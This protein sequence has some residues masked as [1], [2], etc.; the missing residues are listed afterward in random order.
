MRGFAGSILCMAAA[1][2]MVGCGGDGGE[3]PSAAEAPKRRAAPARPATV[4]TA[5]KPPAPPAALDLRLQPGQQFPL[6]KVVEQTLTQQSAA[7]PLIARTRLE[8][9]LV[10]NVDEVASDGR[11]RLRAVYQRVRYRHDVPGEWF[12]F[13][14]ADANAT[15]PL[16]AAPCRGLVGNGF[17]FW[18]GPDRRIAEVI[19]F[20][21]FLEQCV[22][23]VP[24]AQRPAVLEQFA[25]LVD[26]AEI[27]NFVDDGI[28]LL[29]PAGRPDARV[30]DTWT[31]ER[32]LGRTLPLNLT[33]QCTLT[34][35]TDAAAEIDVAGRVAPT[36]IIEPVAGAH[37]RSPGLRISVR[38]GRSTGHCTVDRQSGLP[39]RSTIERHVEMLVEPAGAPAFV[40]HKH[41]VT[42]IESFPE[43]P[44]PRTALLRRVAAE[45]VSPG[46]SPGREASQPVRR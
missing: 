4:Q 31:R 43:Q 28:G 20:G 33:C 7:E 8:L 12:E 46:A 9:W 17:S 25:Q 29:P 34:E 13:D 41:L 11:A 18:I 23:D 21:E 24:L 19:G 10:A 37:T 6:R 39:L 35:L 42:T 15:L 44:T 38:G 2:G 3:A 36:S 40:Q 16:A 30:G 27:A 32:R 1:A 22:R 26:M 5:Q 14:S 45:P